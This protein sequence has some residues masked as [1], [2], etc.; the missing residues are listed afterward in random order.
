MRY[1]PTSD[2][3][4]PFPFREG[5][6]GGLGRIDSMTTPHTIEEAW[7][8]HDIG[9]GG[10]PDGGSG[11]V[12]LAVGA[13]KCKAFFGVIAVVMIALALRD[14]QMQVLRHDTYV[15]Q[16]EGNRSRTVLVPVERGVVYDRN[17]IPL[18]RNVPNFTASIVPADLPKDPSARMDAIGRL[19]AI[20]AITP[21][22]IDAK[23]G[24]FSKYPAAAVTVGEHLTHDQ[25]VLARIE[26]ARAPGVSLDVTT[27]R[28]Y[29]DT[30]KVRSL[31]HILGYEGRAT[32]A[33]IDRADGQSYVPTDLIGKTGLERE[34]EQTLR[35]S[36]GR[37]RVEVDALGRQK[38]V[39]SEDLGEPGRNLVLSID[40]DLQKQAEQ[41]LDAA[42][43]ASG[44]KRGSAVVSDPG[45]GE[46]LALVSEPAFDANLF[47]KG[48]SADDYRKLSEDQDHPLFPRAISASLPSGSVFKMIVASAALQEGVITP[49]TSFLSTGGIHVDKWFFPDWKAGG[50]GLTNVTKALAESV[51]TFFYIVGGGKDDFPG[52]GVD[53]ITSYARKF[54]LGSPL[55]LDLPG[56]GAGFLP[57]KQW[58]ERVKGE[59]WY[60]GDTYHLAIGQ[61]D[62]LVTPLQI[63][64]VTTIIANGGKRI[65]PRIVNAVTS[66]DGARVENPPEVLD[67]QVV[68]ASA[69]G[70]V[71][72]GMRAAVTSGSARS[73]GDLPV[74]VAAKTGTAQWKS[75]APNHAWFTSFA[76]YDKPRIAVTVMI[77]EGGEGSAFPAQAAKRIYAWYFGKH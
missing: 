34:Y 18:V 62:L 30:D 41:A 4:G 13:A 2:I 48:I 44:R 54:G 24:E 56:E 71:R 16:A 37:K 55:G 45:T 23:L 6:Y 66:D 35:G 7:P 75:G 11:Y 57:S 49:S 5:A 14:W 69:I 3:G 47:A 10:R 74:A 20:L 31:S 68:E 33:E 22:D 9:A 42:L 8:E 36:Y 26:S 73:L 39:I 17:G 46:V 29:P 43:K 51:N 27:R 52:L 50:H 60:I 15:R 63:N 59:K 21:E 53:R 28:E 12:G 40:L 77:E 25:A 58:K 65:R 19:A 61:G 1:D 64:E 70:E 67:P 76:P 72:K 38:K 32:Q